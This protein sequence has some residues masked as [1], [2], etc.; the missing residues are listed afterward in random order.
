ME[1]TFILPTINRKN[2]VVRAIE[3]CLQINV[4]SDKIKA[5]VLV[6]D[7]FSDDGAWEI[8]KEKYL[9]NPNVILKQ[10]DRKL[11]FQETAFLALRDVNTEYC[12]YMYN[13]DLISNFYYEIANKM[14]ECNQNFIMGY[15][16]NLN[17][18]NIYQFL[19]PNFKLVNTNNIILNYFGFYKSLEYNSLPVSPVPSLS[20]TKLLREWEL[21]VRE[22]VKSSKFR[23]ELMLKI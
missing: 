13:D 8:L 5:E 2:Y 12:T 1:I 14:R 16:V 11:G 20:K 4:I 7:G 9:N 6:Y 18:D 15:G 21:E 19:K 3:S 22:F 23:N 17:V 10:V